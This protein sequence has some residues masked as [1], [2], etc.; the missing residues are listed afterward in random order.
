MV[1][2]VAAFGIVTL[3]ASYWALAEREALLQREDNPRRV[4]AELNIQRGQIVDRDGQVLAYSDPANLPAE[5]TSRIYPHP[6]V[7]SA[8]GHYSYQYGVAGIEADYNAFLN[9]DGLP[10]ARTEWSDALLNRFRRGGD[11]R[12]TLDLDLQLR[13][14]QA[15]QGQ[16]GAA[17][18]VEIPTGAVRAM[19]SLPAYDPN[20][21]AILGPLLKDNPENMRVLN[22]VID[23][24]YQPGGALQTLFLSA[25][26]AAGV[27]PD[28]PTSG[29][30][31][32]LSQP[33]LR[34]DCAT[35]ARIETLAQAYQHG[36]P[37]PFVNALDRGL[38][39]EGLESSLQAAGLAENALL[40]GFEPE[41]DPTPATPLLRTSPASAWQADLAGQG[42]L[43]VT[44]VQMIQVIAAV[45]NQGA[46]LPLHLVEATRYP[47]EADWHTVT[48]P[49]STLAIMQP[50][51]AQQ[52]QS[53]L[54]SAP[55][56]AQATLF[57]HLSRA[58]AGNREY[59]WFLG[60]VMTEDGSP[61]A[62]VMVLEGQAGQLDLMQAIAVAQSA[63]AVAE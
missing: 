31:I 28:S 50:A 14:H 4:L 59:A 15:M 8:V 23:G 53:L 42:Q 30:A 43:T 37:G 60:W 26:L 2:I 32:Q 27:S 6:Q 45:L 33:A 47:Q 63:L 22:C 24:V 13:L 44:P 62:I 46:G 21:M 41:A 48:I 1:G 25:F 29:E 40:L 39:A 36:C 18:V 58:Y 7:V 35:S 61:L 16:R 19:V 20:Q 11:L 12:S 3:S 34:L 57:G 52:I 54:M 9:G 17:L 56:N 49:P 5:G 55:W 38:S 51:I 10:D